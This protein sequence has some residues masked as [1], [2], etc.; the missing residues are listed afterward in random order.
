M[1]AT[2]RRAV[3]ILDVSFS[4][5]IST[6]RLILARCVLCASISRCRSLAL[7]LRRSAVVEWWLDIKLGNKAGNDL[8]LYGQLVAGQAQGLAGFGLG[9][10]VH[11]EQ[12]G[13]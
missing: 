7:I 12:H 2:Y 4:W 6:P 9:Q 8:G 11:F 3:R 1:R 5:R 13:A 10:T